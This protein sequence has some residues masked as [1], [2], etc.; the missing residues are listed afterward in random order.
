M[1]MEEEENEDDKV[2]EEGKRR[3]K[4]I[5]KRRRVWR[6]RGK[7][8]EEDKLEKRKERQKG[9]GVRYAGGVGREKII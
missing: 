6:G 3:R 1:E 7:K 9:V 4:V 5:R 2:G 8:G